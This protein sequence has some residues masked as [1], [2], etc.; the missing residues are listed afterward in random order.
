VV[1][2][3][4][5]RV[6]VEWQDGSITRNHKSTDLVPFELLL[7]QHFFPNEFVTHT[8][9]GRTGV[10]GRVNAQD[11]VT[12][13]TWCRELSPEGTWEGLSPEQAHI[14]DLE[15]SLYSITKNAS[16]LFSR[17]CNVL[18]VLCAELSQGDENISWGGELIG[19]SGDQ[20][21]IAWADGTVEEGVSPLAVA[22][23]DEHSLAPLDDAYDNDAEGEYYEDA[24]QAAEGGMP[25]IMQGGQRFAF[26]AG[27]DGAGEMGQNAIAQDLVLQGWME[28]AARDGYNSD[29]VSLVCVYRVWFYPC[30]KPSSRKYTRMRARQATTK[31]VRTSTR[32]WT[33][34]KLYS[35]K[36]CAS[37][38][39]KKTNANARLAK[40]RPGRREGA[41]R[42]KT[43]KKTRRK[44]AR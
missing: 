20:L 3:T 17:G 35:G 14:V 43:R 9:T 33:T 6:D 2:R 30:L 24:E 7:D 44:R 11:R 10:C 41:S 29:Q 42:G 1:V 15:V 31:T 16:F 21:T 38:S 12:T 32:I 4:H 34:R 18:R 23:F 19:I 40:R 8:E 36:S 25:F 5:T 13:V 27:A 37:A 39:W 26:P 28:N 22:P